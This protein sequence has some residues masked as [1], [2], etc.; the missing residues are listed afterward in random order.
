MDGDLASGGRQHRVSG[1]DGRAGEGEGIVSS[2]G[3]GA[4]LLEHEGWARRR[5]WRGG[6]RSEE[7]G[8]VLEFGKGE[9][10]TWSGLREHL[11]SVYRSI[12]CRARIELE[13]RL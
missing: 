5:W 7:A 10:I 9:G 8:G 13:A 4:A 6:G 3:G 12:W 2:W 11:Q 1:A